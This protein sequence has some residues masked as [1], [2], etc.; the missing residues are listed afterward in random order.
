MFF[1]YFKPFKFL[2]YCRYNLNVFF[3]NFIIYWLLAIFFISFMGRYQNQIHFLGKVDIKRIL[4]ST[5]SSARI[6]FS[7]EV[8]SMVLQ[9]YANRIVSRLECHL[10]RRHVEG[11]RICRVCGSTRCLYYANTTIVCTHTFRRWY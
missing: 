5:R 6:H 8:D 7:Y 3:F 11:P 1:Y 4:F 10:V 2:W 9:K